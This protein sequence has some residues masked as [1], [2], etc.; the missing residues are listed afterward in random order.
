MQIRVCAHDVGKRSSRRSVSFLP[1]R[2][3]SST[4]T[5]D[6]AVRDLHEDLP[7]FG[8]DDRPL[9]FDAQRAFV[10]VKD[11]SGGDFG[12]GEACHIG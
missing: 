9:A 1:R 3:S 11:H 7:H 10:L 4:L 5:A 8:L 2:C 6:S 12:N